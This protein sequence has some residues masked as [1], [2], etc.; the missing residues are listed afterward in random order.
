MTTTT[1]PVVPE[2][3]M[4]VTHLLSTEEVCVSCE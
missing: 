2:Q 3:E 1:T 4:V